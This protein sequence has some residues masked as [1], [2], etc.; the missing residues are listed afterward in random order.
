[1]ILGRIVGQV[2]A[3]RKDARLESRRLVLVRP[4]AWH[5]P[6]HDSDAIVAADPVGAEVGQDVVV[7]M[8]D[9]AR[10][11]LG[12]TRRPVEAAVAAIVDRV[13]LYPEAADRPRFA[14]R[15]GLEPVGVGEEA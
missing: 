12:D 7:C 11:S 8:G 13:E 15:P 1:M 14:F 5:R 2:W 9:P 6:D 4:L 3:T 10:R